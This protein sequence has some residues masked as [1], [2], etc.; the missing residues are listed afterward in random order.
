MEAIGSRQAIAASSFTIFIGFIA[1]SLVGGVSSKGADYELVIE[2]RLIASRTPFAITVALDSCVLV[3]AFIGEPDL[4]FI[5]VVRNK[6]SATN[7]NVHIACAA[8][9]FQGD[10]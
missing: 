4:N 3:C 6:V 5:V 2:V 8:T 1:R 9:V 7:L 10:C